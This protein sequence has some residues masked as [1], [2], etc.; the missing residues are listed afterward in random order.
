MFVKVGDVN[1]KGNVA[2]A[3]IAARAIQAG[4]HVLHP[5]AEHGRYDLVFEFVDSFTRVQ[6]KWARLQGD[7]VLAN[8]AGYRRTKEGS[9]RSRYSAEE[10][11]AFA[12]Y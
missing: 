8:L 12:I 11:D 6:C 7:V 5:Q 3:I 9:A 1:H 10:I 4:V 2:E